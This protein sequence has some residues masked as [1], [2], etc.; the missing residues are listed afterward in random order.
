MYKDSLKVV[1]SALLCSYLLQQSRFMR[2]AKREKLLAVASAIFIFC[3]AL[4]SFVIRP[5]TA[6]IET[7]SRVIPEKQAELQKLHIKGRQY[8]LLR[9]SMEDWRK[10]IALTEQTAEL[11]SNLESLIRQCKL[12]KNVVTM[13]QENLQVDESYYESVVL[14][15]LENLTIRQLIDLLQKV[16]GFAKQTAPSNV[17]AKVK[18]LHISKNPSNADLLDSTIEIHTPRLIQ[19]QVARR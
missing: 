13:K 5:V 18:S 8:V 6:R 17:W 19:S 16:E 1:L 14:T 7:L 2:L 11:L 15:K 3:W 4:F 9:D 10:K 12:E